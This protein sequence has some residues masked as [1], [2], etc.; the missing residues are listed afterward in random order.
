MLPE[1]LDQIVGPGD[2]PGRKQMALCLFRLTQAHVVHHR[3]QMQVD[4]RDGIPSPLH[5]QRGLG[6]AEAFAVVPLQIGIV[7][8]HIDRK[9]A[10]ARRQQGEI[11]P[12][13]RRLFGQG[14]MQQHRAGR[15]RKRPRSAKR[16]RRIRPHAL[17]KGAHLHQCIPGMG[18]LPDREIG[19]GINQAG[20]EPCRQVGACQI[21]LQH[22]HGL[23]R[24]PPEI[25]ILRKGE[26]PLRALLHGFNAAQAAPPAQRPC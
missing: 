2:L 24:L 21:G 11:L 12:G 4:G 8:L 10:K 13:V 14:K 23:L 20:R 16:R 9:G 1:A 26:L 19:I 15:G 3:R 17:Q 22:L 7:R 6:H 18:D 5:G 25:V